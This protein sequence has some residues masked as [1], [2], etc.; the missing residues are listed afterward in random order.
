MEGI[1]IHC[2]AFVKKVAVA[3]AVNSSLGKNAGFSY[4]DGIV[5]VK[6]NIQWACFYCVRAGVVLGVCVEWN[7]FVL[8]PLV[9]CKTCTVAHGNKAVKEGNVSIDFWV[10]KDKHAVALFAAVK[11]GFALFL[12][13]VVFSLKGELCSSMAT[14]F[15]SPRLTSYFFH[16][17]L[18]ALNV[19]G[20]AVFYYILKNLLYVC[21]WIR[22]HWGGCLCKTAYFPALGEG[23][24]IVVGV[25][26]NLC[27][28]RRQNCCKNKKRK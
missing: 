15:Y 27:E 6:V 1:V 11:A 3:S 23:V 14:G 7:K 28:C 4:C 26:R 10:C 21:K 18:G 24:E 2:R 12:F 19:C 9:C 20:S 22:P 5:Y 25:N 13:L 8:V 16:I 17:I